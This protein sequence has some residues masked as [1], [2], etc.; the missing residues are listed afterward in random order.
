MKVTLI[1]THSLTSLLHEGEEVVEEVLPLGAVGQFVELQERGEEKAFSSRRRQSVRP[2]VRRE[3]I[4]IMSG[5]LS[6]KGG[7]EETQIIRLTSTGPRE[8]STH[9]REGKLRKEGL[10]GGAFLRCID[11]HWGRRRGNPLLR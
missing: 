8:Y 10:L 1:H 5:A 9:A 7:K 2:T 4:K 3:I 11:I 6:T